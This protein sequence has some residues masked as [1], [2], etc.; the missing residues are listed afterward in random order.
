MKICTVSQSFYPYV[1]GVTRYLQ[2]LGKRLIER[3]DEMI[4]VHLKTPDMP[5]Y[6]VV[7]SIRVYRMAESVAL[8]D[9]M[10]GYLRFKELIIDTTHG[11]RQPVK[12]D[13]R[14]QHG[15]FDYLG[16]NLGMFEKVKAVYEEEQFDIL[17]V[18]DFQVMP[19][20][21]MLKDVIDVPMLFTW[22]IP[23]TTV[24]PP[25]WRDF[26]VRYLHYYD[27]VIFSTDEYMR[28]AVES[29]L[30]PG[31]VNKINPFIETEKFVF[32]GENTF[33]KKFDIPENH[34]IVLCISRMDPRKGQEYLIKAMAEVTPKHPDTTCVFIGNGSM[35]K[36]LMGRT[37]RLEDLKA[38][39]KSL[40]LVEKVRFLGKVGEEDLLMAYDACDMLVLP[41][42]NEGF[43]L[44]LS[45]AMCFGKPLIGSNVGGI[46]EQIVDGVNGYLFKP[47]DHEELAQYIGALL[48]HPEICKQMGAIGKELVNMR[49]CVERGFKDH[50]EIYDN[51]YLQKQFKDKTGTGESLQT[52]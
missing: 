3:G 7:D 22:H 29:G 43:G 30:N 18:H 36:K 8:K 28:T 32:T 45:E 13:D 11:S 52:E 4:V 38:L 23:F 44:V 46:P 17:H 50:C 16:F 31:Q 10:E 35:S 47:G 26:M 48:E 5:D 27:Q 9:S 25:D 1:G 42:I 34:H 41:S 19:L 49:F 51:I 2:A 6:E 40:G 20:A 15:Y 37:D 33:R 21:F 39:T 14:F 24:M 12:V